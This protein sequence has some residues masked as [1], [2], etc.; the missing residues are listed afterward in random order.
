MFTSYTQKAIT[1][2]CDIKYE[3]NVGTA[4]YYSLNDSELQGILD[5]LVN[6]G[7][8]CLTN[9]EYPGVPSSY[10]YCHPNQHVTLYKVLIALN[11]GVY[12][13]ESIEKGNREMAEKY[14]KR[15]NMLQLLDQMMHALL[16]KVPITELY[17]ISK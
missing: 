17:Q 7:F 11:E 6:A 16:E 8:I 13:I 3:K 12:P 5:K 9:P 2:L 1:I 4:E 15:I 10:S 14:L